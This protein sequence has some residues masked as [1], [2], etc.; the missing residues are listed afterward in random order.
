M[1]L[2]KLS[3]AIAALS[4]CAAAACGAQASASPLPSHPFVSTSGKAQLWMRPDI[5][6]VK[7]ETGTQHASAETAAGQL[8]ELSAGVMQLLADH[9][10]QEAD[11]ES[12]E[13]E[14]KAVPVHGQ[15][16]PAYSIGRLFH[17]RVRD[18]AQWPDLVARLV[19]MEHVTNVSS[20]FDRTDSDAI[21]TQ[22][23]EAAASDARTKGSTLAKAFGRK[24]GPAV[25][26][27]RGPLDK[28]GA[29]FIE[30]QPG[31][32]ARGTAPQTGK[33]SVPDSIPYSQTVNAIFILK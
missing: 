1:K 11:I 8:Q 16:Q 17:A 24:L 7:F 26:V 19:E 6:E 9:G 21:N 27:A 23:M 20:S 22:L 25:A 4:L 14:K 18:L 28:V 30:Q 31:R 32:E 13:V 15:E 29:P 2:M 5:G 3:T 12:Y 33:Y 10:V